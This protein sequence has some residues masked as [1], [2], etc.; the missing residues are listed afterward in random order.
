MSFAYIEAGRADAICTRTPGS[1]S[2][3]RRYRRAGSTKAQTAV[4]R[5]NSAKDRRYAASVEVGYLG[6]VLGLQAF[7]GMTST[8]A[9]RTQ[10]RI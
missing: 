1:V 4:S 8:T 7:C 2:I 5:I 6:V 3:L 9:L 10:L